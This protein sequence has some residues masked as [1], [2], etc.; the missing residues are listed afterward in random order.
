LPRRLH[1]QNIA[2]FVLAM[3]LVSALVMLYVSQERFFYYFDYAGFDGIAADLASLIPGNFQRLVDLVK[4][5]LELDYNY[6]YALPVL[7]FIFVLGEGRQSYE[8]GLTLVY[9]VP[10]LLALGAVA[11]RLFPGLPRASFWITFFTAM[12]F[13]VAWAPLLRGY[14]DVG[15]A[16]C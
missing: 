8:L 10:Y 11:T 15:A 6:F 13:P 3:L 4:T 14:P 1:L 9:Q 7:P 12:L 5:Y 2:L 16:F